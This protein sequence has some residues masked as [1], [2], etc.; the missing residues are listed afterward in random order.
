MN[1]EQYLIVDRQNAGRSQIGEGFLKHFTEGNPNIQIMSAG[2]DITGMK[3]KYDNHPNPY[4]ISAMQE[5][6]IDISHQEITQ[7]T[8][9]LLQ[10]STHVIV[11]ADEKELPEYFNDFKNKTLLIPI[12]DPA[13]GNDMKKLRAVRD[14]IELVMSHV[15]HRE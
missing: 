2:L 15:A 6:G 3:D 14:Q 4:V 12:E 7:V 1:K 11:L 13:P 5:K 8:P 9:E 10:E